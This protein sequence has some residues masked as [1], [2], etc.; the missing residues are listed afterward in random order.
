MDGP[1]GVPVHD[2]ALVIQANQ[3]SLKALANLL[4]NVSMDERVAWDSI[5]EAKQE[6]VLFADQRT[7]IGRDIMERTIAGSQIQTSWSNV[8]RG[9]GYDNSSTRAQLV[10][11]QVHYWQQERWGIQRRWN[12]PP[13]TLLPKI[14]DMM[15]VDDTF[16]EVRHE[17]WEAIDNDY[18]GYVDLGTLIEQDYA[19]AYVN[20]KQE[21]GFVL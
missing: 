10:A 13:L 18:Y 5:L 19:K 7:V 14:T 4:R 20:A 9:G 1:H 11:R 8:Y 15:P 16:T 17:A 21:M 2:G 6:F 12:A 3:A